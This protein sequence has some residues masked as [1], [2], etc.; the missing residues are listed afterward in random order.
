LRALLQHGEGGRTDERRMVCQHLQQHHTNRV[1]V[2]AAI[3]AAREHLRRHVVLCDRHP[4]RLLTARRWHLAEPEVRD[5]R[6]GALDK[7][8]LRLQM[9]VREPALMQ[10]SDPAT[11]LLQ[12]TNRNLAQLRLADAK[13]QR[14]L[15]GKRRHQVWD[16]H[17]HAVILDRDEVAVVQHHE[18]PRL[19]QIA[20]HNQ[21]H[22]CIAKL[23]KVDRICATGG[24]PFRH[25]D[26]AIRITAKLL[27]DLKAWHETRRSVVGVK[28]LP[29]GLHDWHGHQ[30]QY[31][32]Q[33]VGA[34]LRHLITG[35]GIASPRHKNSR[36]TALSRMPFAV[37]A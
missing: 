10:R 33:I 21:L 37:Q 16:A 17:N 27:C 11:R 22:L 8:I 23:Q 13:A 3:R 24:L 4:R 25:A 19:R 1:D 20:L 34:V 7:H 14:L 12:I 15:P 32:S 30:A 36:C 18:I 29:V 9:K 26:H 5:S 6:D 35:E 2:G 28:R 31:C